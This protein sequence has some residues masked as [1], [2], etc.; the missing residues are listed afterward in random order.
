MRFRRK[1]A[2][3]E[4][5][6]VETLLNEPR[7]DWPEWA[8][9]A[10]FNE[11][12]ALRPTKDE[13]KILSFLGNQTAHIGGWIVRNEKGELHAYTPDAFAAVYEPLPAAQR[14]M[15]AVR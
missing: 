7:G 5:V 9:R 13:V 10:W 8:Q 2:E 1:P 15:E 11:T 4:A 6:K 14:D 3:I 12:L